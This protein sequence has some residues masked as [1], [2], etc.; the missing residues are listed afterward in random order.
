MKILTFGDKEAWVDDEDYA[1]VMQFAWYVDLNGYIAHRNRTESFLLH[2]FVLNYTGPLPI[3]HIDRNRL[4]NQKSNLRIVEQ[5][6]NN[7]NS[8]RPSHNTSGIKGVRLIEAT[9]KYEAFITIKDRKK[10]IGTFATEEGAKEARQQYE[11]AI[12]GDPSLRDK[13][14][15]TVAA[16]NQ[17]GVTGVSFVT[18]TGKWKAKINQRHL[19]FFKT[20]EEAI[21]AR[22]KAEAQDR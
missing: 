10:H 8:G 4:N 6:Q 1:R 12:L 21:T 13:A 11:Q 18:R 19:G 17:S 2:R 15:G 20:K 3:D 22:L 16:N 5:W 14:F 9:G 7:L